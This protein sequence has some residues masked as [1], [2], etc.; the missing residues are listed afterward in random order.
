[1]YACGCVDF[2]S[3][4]VS[5]D[6]CWSLAQCTRMNHTLDPRDIAFLDI[7][8]APGVTPAKRSCK[9]SSPTGSA[10]VIVARVGADSCTTQPVYYIEIRARSE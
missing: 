7:D 2:L 5:C 9:Y 3:T 10:K 4:K 1:M 6:K 8:D